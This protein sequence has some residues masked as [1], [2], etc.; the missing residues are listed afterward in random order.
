MKQLNAAQKKLLIP[1]FVTLIFGL[2]GG[3][4]RYLHLTRAFDALGLAI[5][6]NPYGLLLTVLSL[7]AIVAL[8]AAIAA[9]RM[10]KASFLSA[11]AIGNAPKATLFP[12]ALGTVIAMLAA[13]K[14]LADA[15]GTFSVWEMLSGLLFLVSAVLTLPV[16]RKL[17]TAT[18]E[19]S[20]IASASL[21]LVFW[22][23]F[24]LIEIY[25]NVSGN[26]AIGTYLCDVMAMI[27]LILMFFACSG[28]FHR[29]V[30]AR[31][32]YLMTTAY[33]FFGTTAL[34]GKGLVCAK[35]VLSGTPLVWANIL[36][37]CVYCYG[38]ACAISLICTFF[39]SEKSDEEQE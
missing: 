24:R 18:N 22:A 11:A 28:Y 34:L 7:A 20:P 37:A 2:F 39:F 6:N 13:I 12:A 8:I 26:P 10:K 19:D 25:R 35:A 23:S 33:F 29:R 31:R 16:I 3:V 17:P 32:V 36:D 1:L 38:F 9:I 21:L 30:T 4:L 5:R 27:S 15:V 14:T